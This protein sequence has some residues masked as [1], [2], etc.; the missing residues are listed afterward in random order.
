MTNKLKRTQHKYLCDNDKST[1]K[2][3]N[4]L[5]SSQIKYLLVCIILTLFEELH[6]ITVPIFLLIFRDSFSE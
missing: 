5:K 6:K 3:T 2:Q 4:K 1:K